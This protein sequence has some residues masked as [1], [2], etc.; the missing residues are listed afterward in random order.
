MTP[1]N[2][3]CFGSLIL[4]IFVFLDSGWLLCDYEF[5]KV[6]ALGSLRSDVANNPCD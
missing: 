5:E 3:P 4:T 6:K 2:L 1:P